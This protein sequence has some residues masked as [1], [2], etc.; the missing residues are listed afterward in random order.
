MATGQLPFPGETS[1]VVFEKILSREPTPPLRLNSELPL[2]LEEIIGKGLEK[3]RNLRYQHAADIRADLQRLK[4]DTG[5]GRSATHTAT[6][7]PTPPPSATPSSA[8]AS[9]AA[10]E[11]QGSATSAPSPIRSSGSSSVAAVASEHK[12]SLGI[13]ALIILLLIAG[14]AYGVYAYINRTRP[15]PFSSFSA[16]PVTDFGNVEAAALS[17]DG[18]FVVSVL[19]R[20]NHFSLSLRNLP[21]AS[22]TIIM[23]AGTHALDVPVFSPDSNYIYFRKSENLGDA[24]DLMRAPLLGGTPQ[25]ISKDVDTNVAISPDGTRIVFARANDPEVDKWR[26]IEAAADGS[27]EKALLIVPG[28]EEPWYVAWSADGKRIAA[29]FSGADKSEIR[30]F[31]FASGSMQLFV[32]YQDK[33]LDRVAWAPDGRW[34]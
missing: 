9:A 17:P 8:S 19:R 22:D 4:R 3:D 15:L 28:Q 1:G 31:D 13:G 30:M 18:K 14:A 10:S 24:F 34:I 6:A 2:K 11:A 20:P 29:S 21:T 33:F 5:S 26:L 7:S 32:Q 23:D 27:G 12:F 25:V 16:T